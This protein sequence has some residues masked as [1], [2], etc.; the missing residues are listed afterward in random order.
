MDYIKNN[1]EKH[2]II[3]KSTI[4]ILHHMFCVL[5]NGV[6]S[7]TF[8]NK[9]NSK[10]Y[11]SISANYFNN[12]EPE[13]LPSFIYPYS[14]CM[15]FQPFMCYD[16]VKNKDNVLGLQAAMKYFIKCLEITTFEMMIERRR[17]ELIEYDTFDMIEHI[18]REK[19]I[20]V[21]KLPEENNKKLEELK[22]YLTQEQ[23]KRV[24]KK[25]E[26]FINNREEIE[27]TLNDWKRAIPLMK[28][29]F[30]IE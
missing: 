1:L 27:Q 23:N 25:I 17:K 19:C 30:N 15:K 21:N 24:P 8:S 7:K 12:L 9:K 26:E 3:F 18:L 2:S 16:S 10:N 5:G 20:D 6:D 29:Q 28:K 4:D 22:A 13:C 11:L 14:D